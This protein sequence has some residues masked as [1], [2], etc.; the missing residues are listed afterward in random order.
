[1]KVKFKKLYPDAVIPKYQKNGDCGLDLTCITKY[2]DTEENKI[3]YDT[4]LAVEIPQGYFGMI[5]PRSSSYKT[6][7]RLKNSL[8]VIDENFRGSMRFMYTLP[9][10]DK[11]S[12]NVGDRIGQLIILPY[13]SIEPIEVHELSHTERGNSGFGSSGA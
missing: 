4:G 12:F 10:K 2:I 1:M 6:G 5:V 13:P 8:G 3:E 11:E 9:E 7:Q